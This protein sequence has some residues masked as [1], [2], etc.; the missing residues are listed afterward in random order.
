M[1]SPEERQPGLVTPEDSK[2]RMAG[3]ENLVDTPQKRMKAVVLTGL[4]GVLAMEAFSV[5]AQAEPGEVAQEEEPP[6]TP[7]PEAGSSDIDSYLRENLGTPFADL[8]VDAQNYLL[9]TPY[10][11]LSVDG[12]AYASEHFGEIIVARRDAAATPTPEAG[13]TLVA[14][15]PTPT[16][17]E[18]LV[19]MAPADLVTASLTG[20]PR[21]VDVQPAFVGARVIE[22]NPQ[23]LRPMMGIDGRP[24]LPGYYTERP[25]NLAA[26]FMG[27]EDEADIVETANNLNGVDADYDYIVGYFVNVTRLGDA[28][29]TSRVVYISFP[30]RYVD[31]NGQITQEPANRHYATV[32]YGVGGQGNRM[33]AIN[34]S[35]QIIPAGSGSENGTF[36]PGNDRN[37]TIT[38]VSDDAMTFP[39]AEGVQE[40]RV[41][42]PVIM[43]VIRNAEETGRVLENQGF[44][45]AEVI[46]S[47]IDNDPTNDIRWTEEWPVPMLPEMYIYT[48]RD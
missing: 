37:T 13:R 47:L 33:Y 48:M 29:S 38:W 41:G 36:R 12:Q 2:V 32:G 34:E 20:Y 14:Q 28:N 39:T 19:A 1:S 46:E 7:T 45:V 5:A 6:I 3:L 42:D 16:P 4:T 25:A 15:V 31:A 11:N 10:Q 43:A 30:A 9:S 35:G 40:L 27:S 26:T 8:R 22:L 24:I 17:G 44:P 23:T 21:R 18:T